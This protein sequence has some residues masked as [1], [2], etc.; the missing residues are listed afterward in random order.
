MSR[1]FCPHPGCSVILPH[2]VARCPD[3]ELKAWHTP[4]PPTRI[5][6]RQNQALKRQL[7]QSDPKCAH[8]RRILLPS[9]MIRD[10]IVPL[11]ESGQ[12][13]QPTNEGCQGLCSTC[14]DAKTQAESLRAKQRYA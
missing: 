5:R 10:H 3:H 13:D 6:G 14:H 1:H 12:Q 7:W 4:T 2:G 8:C 9:Q 11:T